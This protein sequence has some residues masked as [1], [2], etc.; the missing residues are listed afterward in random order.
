MDHREY[1]MDNIAG[2]LEYH[3]RRAITYLV[4]AIAAACFWYFSPHASRFT[5]A[6]LVISLGGLMLAAKGVFLLRKSSEGLGLTE[7][8]LA[9]LSET[10]RRKVAQPLP[11]RAAQIMQ[12]FGSGPL[13]LW[14]FISLFW[15]TAWEPS[16]P[17]VLPIFLI[18]AII[19]GAGWAMRRLTVDSTP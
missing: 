13:L 11:A 3:P 1:L 4:L 17:H 7:A 9:A 2:D 18:G 5:T 16:K 14:P 15:D 8:E 12:D 19:F 6:P 10:A